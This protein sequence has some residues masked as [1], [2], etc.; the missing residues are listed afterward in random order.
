MNIRGA[1]GVDLNI[2]GTDVVNVT[3]AGLNVVG[4]LTGDTSLTLDTTTITTAEL[5][6]LDSVTAG[7]VAASKA[8]VVDASKDASG[9]RKV[10]ATGAFIIGSAE[11]D[12]TDM[13]KLDG[14][15]NGTAA[16][17]KALV[18]DGSAGATGIGAL[19]IASM[20]SNWTNAGRTVADLGTITTVDIN[21]GTIDGATLGGASAVTVTNMDCNGGSMDGVT[22]GA[23]SAAPATVTAFAAAFSS[24]VTDAAYSARTTDFFIGCNTIGNSVVVSLPRASTVEAGRMFVV[25]DVAGYSTG[26]NLVKVTGSHAADVIEGSAD[27]VE[28]D[29]AY[30]AVNFISDGS[31]KW[32]IW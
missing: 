25:K 2:N 9:F 31:S 28:I 32:Y 15:T 11:L 20:A 26:S 16:N 5:G 30:G 13:E 23:A 19:G 22:I 7:T 24:S 29:S 6:V 12:E 27:K 14:I 10:T 4:T 17:N 3:S 8:V 21:G 18:L 1:T